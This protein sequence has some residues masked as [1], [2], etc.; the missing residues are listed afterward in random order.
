MAQTARPSTPGIPAGVPTRDYQYSWTS[1]Q[2]SSVLGMAQCLEAFALGGGGER[3]L[4]V[5]FESMDVVDRQSCTVCRSDATAR[6]RANLRHPPHPIHHNRPAVRRFRTCRSK[7]AERP[8]WQHVAPAGPWCAHF[9]GLER[10]R[11]HWLCFAFLYSLGLSK[12][13]PFA[14]MEA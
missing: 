4:S 1:L 2:S 7:S 8:Q 11:P 14:A 9:D 6:K 10:S 13:A 12:A 5:P 3:P